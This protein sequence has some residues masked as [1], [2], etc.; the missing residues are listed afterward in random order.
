MTRIFKSHSAVGKRTE[1]AVGGDAGPARAHPGG[2]AR[3]GRSGGTPR[4]PPAKK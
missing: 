4:P 1:E 3:G 2:G